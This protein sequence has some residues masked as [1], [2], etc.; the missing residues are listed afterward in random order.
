MARVIGKRIDHNRCPICEA[1]VKTR[2]RC[3]RSDSICE[4]GHKWHTCIPCQVYVEGHASHSLSSSSCTCGGAGKKQDIQERMDAA[5][6]TRE[7][8]ISVK[9]FTLI[10]E[11]RPVLTLSPEEAFALGRELI[12]QAKDDVDAAMDADWQRTEL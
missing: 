12:Q 11:G 3:M 1:K 6:D 8:R 2:C 5:D 7:P 10:V 4:N 9:D